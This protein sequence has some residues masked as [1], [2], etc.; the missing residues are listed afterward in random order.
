M[1]TLTEMS[2]NTDE[3]IFISPNGQ[4]FTNNSNIPKEL[5]TFVPHSNY[6]FSK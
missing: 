6:V 5:V 4:K 2:N 3:G 1:S